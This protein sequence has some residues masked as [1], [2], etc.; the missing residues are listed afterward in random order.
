MTTPDQAYNGSGYV[1]NEVIALQLRHLETTVATLATNLMAEMRLLR[2][3]A[4]RRDV[5]D[6]QRRADQAE[7][8]QLRKELAQRADKGDMEQVKEEL[9]ESRQRKWAIWLSLAGV[10]FALGKDLITSLMQSGG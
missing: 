8:A 1:S 10:A 4:V 7:L 3:D 2:Q 5:Y 9:K 6:E